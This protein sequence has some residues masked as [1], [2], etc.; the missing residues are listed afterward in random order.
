M[1]KQLAKEVEMIKT[2]FVCPECKGPLQNRGR[3]YYCSNCENEYPLIDGIPC[4]EKSVLSPHR[5][6][7]KEKKALME[8]TKRMHWREALALELKDK[9]PLRYEWIIYERAADWKVLLPLNKDSTVLDAGCGWGTLTF[10]LARD[11]KAVMALDHSTYGTEFIRIRGTQDG[12]SNVFPVIGSVLKLPFP[13]N[14][15]DLVVLNGV[16]EWI[17]LSD[18][19]EEPTDVQKRLLRETRRVLKPRG[20]LYLGIE[21]RWSATY[22]LGQ[23]EGHV[24]LR[25]ISLFP[26]KIAKVYH[27]LVKKSDYRVY[28]HSL[29]DYL[30][31]LSQA[32]FRSV[33]TYVPIPQ[34]HKYSHMVPLENV[35]AVKYYAQ[36]LFSHR[37][38]SAIF[39]NKTVKLLH[40]YRLMK[41][42]VPCYSFIAGTRCEDTVINPFLKSHWQAI[43]GKKTAEPNHFSYILCSGQNRIVLFPFD[44]D[45]KIPCHVLKILRKA[46]E[47]P[48][49]AEST[50]FNY[51]RG[52]KSPFVGKSIPDILYS[53]K[54][55]NRQVLIRKVTAGTCLE[56]LIV[57]KGQPF[58]KSRNKRNLTVVMNWLIE[59]HRLTKDSELFLGSELVNRYFGP[60]LDAVE[61]H[62]GIITDREYMLSGVQ[63]LKTSVEGK[64]FPL[65][66]QH[67]DFG[68]NHIFLDENTVSVIDWELSRKTGEPLYDVF[69]F[70]S[71]YFFLV[72]R[73][74]QTEPIADFETIA[75]FTERTYFKGK[76]DMH[77]AVS[78]LVKRYCQ[79]LEIDIDVAKMLFLWQETDKNKN[80]DILNLFFRKEDK[81]I[82]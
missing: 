60:I 41:Y 16:L 1:G 55:G 74:P 75:K 38:P 47:Q 56:D 17:G 70:L 66:A 78:E 64:C 45:A 71:R 65:V 73:D 23:R 43:A 13:E 22:F 49:K 18:T 11:C 50:V 61:K 62:E 59:F 53:G 5:I 24:N 68:P 12:I 37:K 25:F 4:F 10:Q 31:M 67:R 20:Y 57:K 63:D 46:D 44:D 58:W 28:T 52:I 27:K 39:F 81:F 54:M 21:N 76:D 19:S 14:H 34:Y 36:K 8:L 7:D 26:R 80:F 33:S 6:I 15:F 72:Y 79:S 51:L 42:F 2:H 30:S 29:R 32:G 9:Q 3:A 35:N 69:F 48:I 40:L 82:I 77:N